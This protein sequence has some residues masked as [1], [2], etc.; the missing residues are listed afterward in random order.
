M[1]TSSAAAARSEAAPPAAAPSRPLLFELI[2]A[3]LHWTAVQIGM[4]LAMF[5]NARSSAGL[6]AARHLV[7]NDTGVMLLA[8]R[9]AEAAGLEPA[10]HQKLTNLYVHLGQAR[11]E[12]AAFLRS[13]TLV[14]HQAEQLA[15]AAPVWRSLAAAAGEAIR[16]LE[17]TTRSLLHPNYLA[18]AGVIRKFLESVLRGDLRE[19]ERG[20]VVTPP[21]LRQRR[22][23]PR[24]TLRKPCRVLFDGGEV[25]ATLLDASRE[26]LGLLCGAQIAAN[27]PVVIEV[28][29]RRLEGVV[30]RQ[31]GEQLGVA[32]RKPLFVSD[33]LYR[34]A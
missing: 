9:Y 23:S 4:S 14:P 24:V 17:P 18:D 1:A 10:T 28:D 7:H 6:R 19:V 11:Q 30:A 22:Q 29:G 13:G 2:V 21:Q 25:E 5:A 3:D 8:L 33:P 26:G 27:A 16:V 32:L 20:D 31:Q 15:R 34:V 12:A